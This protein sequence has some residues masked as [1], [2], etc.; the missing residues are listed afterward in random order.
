MNEKFTIYID[1]IKGKYEKNKKFVIKITFFLIIII[2][3]Y[4]FEN[5]NLSS[6]IFQKKYAMK[7][8]KT[9]LN[10]YLNNNYF[11]SS[12]IEHPNISV[13]IPLYNCQNSIYL[14]ISSILYQNFKN[15]EI[16]LINDYS[17]DN[18]SEI[19][20]ELKKKDSRIKIINNQNNMGILYSRSIGVLSSKGKYI[21]CLDNDDLFYDRFLFNNIYDIAENQDYDI[22]EFKCFYVNKYSSQLKL[23]DI[24]DSP[25]NRHPI[26]YSLTQP[27]L[28]IFPISKNNKYFSNDY[29]LWGK[30]IK[31]SIYKKAINMLG[32]E[33]Y[34][35][36]NCWTEDISMLFIIFNI[37]E[38]FIF[39]GIYGIIHIDFKKSTTYT[40]H[41]SKKLMSELFLL[42]IIF[43]FIQNRD[44][45][46][47]YIIQKFIAILKSK[48]IRIINFEHIKYIKILFNKILGINNL[49]NKEKATL[50][51]YLNNLNI[52]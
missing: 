52:K 24:K 13:I 27:E 28:G 31:S 17:Q 25:F 6:V 33:N 18:T 36:Y 21:Y 44:Y 15:F 46:K 30:S 5:H 42:D 3:I 37:A 22:V 50:R 11:L 35:F 43:N 8:I 39:L 45:N 14:S 1:W 10:D 29:H 40:L 23:S 7:Y 34:S 49:N 41:N 9:I 2:L 47:I 32:K 38:S 48:Y 4:L 12:I 26:N 51:K 16:I 19:I 20:N